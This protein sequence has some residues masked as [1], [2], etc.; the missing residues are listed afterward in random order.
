MVLT[1]CS[2]EVAGTP[3][4]TACKITARVRL[5]DPPAGWT[6]GT[7]GSYRL[8]RFQD[9]ILYTFDDVK[10][11]ARLYWRLDPCTGE[12]TPFPSLAPGLDSPFLLDTPAGRVLYA[13]KNGD[14]Y[15]VDR[16]DDPGDDVARKIAGLPS[17][18]F[19]DFNLWNQLGA[20]RYA[21]FFRD[22]DLYSHAGDPTVPALR[23]AVN[24]IDSFPY[25]DAVLTTDATGVRRIDPFTGASELL[26][27]GAQRAELFDVGGS[28]AQARVIWRPAGES[29]LYVRRLGEGKDVALDIAPAIVE[30]GLDVGGHWPPYDGHMAI[31]SDLLNTRILAAARTDTGEAIAVP[32]HT[33]I[34]YA[35]D[36]ALDLTLPDPDAQV[37]AIWE[38]ETGALREWYRGPAPAPSVYALE[39]DHVD[40]YAP[41]PAM[42]AGSLWRVD[43]TTG[44]ARQLLPRVTDPT[45]VAANTYLMEFDVPRAND[46]DALLHDLEYAN[47]DTG[48]YTLLA[49]SVSDAVHVP[50][51]GVIY[52]DA[53]GSEPGVW[54]AP[55]P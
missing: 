1:A 40:Y 13:R 11:P 9:F 35:S 5:A 26:L 3:L 27:G 28:I 32:E 36:R 31:F 21:M 2:D 45:L 48:L 52:L 19:L 53:H 20:A 30:L 49:G 17:S 42:T 29:T 38:P 39:S 43:L 50:G 33:D 37:Q 54:A 55:L 18:G 51:E 23:V 8:H 12:T 16:V 47:V 4:D 46:D 6:P 22:R 24:T 44:E 7:D 25:E 14:Y 15:V 10:D 41:G 34:S